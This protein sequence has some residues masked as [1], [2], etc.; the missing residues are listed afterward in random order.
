MPTPK[1]RLPR[2]SAG[3]FTLEGGTGGITVMCPCGDFL[4]VYKVDRTYRIETP[5]TIDPQRTNPH[6]PFVASLVAEVGSSHPIVARVL[7]QGHEILKSAPLRDHADPDAV[8]IHL[9]RCKELLLVCDRIANEIGQA[10]DQI[11]AQIQS[12]GLS[13]DHSGRGLNPFPQVERLDDHCD[14]YLTHANKAIRTI[15]ELPSMFIRLDRTDS[16][17]EHLAKRLAAIPN[18][19]SKFVQFLEGNADRV[20]YV[21]DLRNFR[22]H[23]K[24]RKTVIRNFGIAPDGRIELPFW[25]V[26]NQEPADIKEDMRTI[27]A[28]LTDLAESMLLFLVMHSVTRVF[29]FVITE[30]PDAQL[31][32]ALPIK[33]RLGVDMS[34]LRKDRCFQ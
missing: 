3:S 15:C 10:V 12:A 13:R 25:R 2:D 16:N 22:E 11:V 32:P 7:L 14:T 29:P 31:D 4:E 17:F 20:R 1:I 28:M 26:D 24:D 18:T 5:E 21:I 27:C 33:Y 6:A 23:P 30:T 19:D 9:H 8:T 34:K